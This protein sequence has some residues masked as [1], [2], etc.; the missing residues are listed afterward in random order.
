MAIKKQLIVM[1]R[2]KK[3]ASKLTTFDRF[4]FGFVAFFVG[5]IRLQ[6]VAAILKPATILR[7]HQMLR[8]RKY[9]KLWRGSI[10][11]NTFSTL[12]LTIIATFTINMNN[13]QSIVSF[14][15]WV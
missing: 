1:N 15:N 5:E 6:K 2:G 11:G 8:D 12:K 10:Q 4:Y 13:M 3:R 7:F 9:S 14:S